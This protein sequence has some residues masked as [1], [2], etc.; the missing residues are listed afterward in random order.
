MEEQISNIENENKEN[1]VMINI[2]DNFQGWLTQQ[3]KLMKM[4]MKKKIKK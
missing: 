3:K 2:C 1:E 4:K